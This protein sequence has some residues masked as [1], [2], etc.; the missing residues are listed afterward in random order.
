[1]KDPGERFLLH[2]ARELKCTKAEL[3]ERLSLD[4]LEEWR[5][6]YVL[7]E[8]ERKEAERK[9]KAKRGR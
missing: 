6:L 4:E 5:A 1:V 3:C 8:K 9:A 2:L 7:E